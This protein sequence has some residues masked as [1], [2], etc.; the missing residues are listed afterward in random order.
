MLFVVLGLFLDSRFRLGMY[1]GGVLGKLR[2]CMK[3]RFRER[4]FWRL[5]FG[6]RVYEFGDFFGLKVEIDFS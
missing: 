2:K 5:F 3:V 1:R 6:E 4:F